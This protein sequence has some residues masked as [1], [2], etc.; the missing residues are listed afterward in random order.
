MRNH[1]SPVDDSR[2]SPG[3]TLWRRVGLV[4]GPLLAALV[5]A[6]P[7]GLHELPGLAS[8]PAAAAAV[9]LWMA[10]WW[11]SEAVPI[12]LTACL[13]LA[14]YP[15]L[16]VA[17][18]GRA[19]SLTLAA[20]GFTDAYIFLFFGG[21]TI[22][23]AMEQWRLHRRIAL[24]IMRLVGTE[25][26]R[27]L[28]GVLIAAE[29]VSLWISNTAT[30]VMMVPIGVALVTELEAREGKRLA[31]YGAALMLAVAYGANV[32]GIG[33]KIGTP[34]NSIFAGFATDRLGVELSFLTFM[35]VGLPFVALFTPVIWWLLWR[36]A[37]RDALGRG[38]AGEV[39]DR[40]LAALG[41][42]S[43]Q[44][45]AVT[46][47]FTAAALLWIFTDVVRPLLAPLVP[48]GF[49]FAG[50][51]YEASV[52]LLAALT[53]AL[54]GKVSLAQLRRVRWDALLLLG[55]S[56]ALASGLEASGLSTWVGGKIQGLSELP[57]L[58]QYAL[59]AGAT[60]ILSAIASNT[61]T[62][63]VMLN[64]LPR[65]LPLLATS[66]MAASCDFALPAGTPP[67]AIVFGSGRVR[68]PVMMKTGVVLDALAVLLLSVWGVLG[69]RLILG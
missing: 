21:M 33:T 41:P 5:Y 43:K 59:T 42:M 55:G 20:A 39:I 14:L 30:A 68:L 61:A 19:E 2:A 6:L 7:S 23:A 69:V 1:P 45:K 60:V 51:H 36:L 67:N 13:P 57:L 18:G 35:A 46:L 58:G 26:R 48:E 17:P 15:A 31:G 66:A 25:P 56:F 52:A 9:A 47:V 8:R 22:G 32:G 24:N 53:L 11:F 28:L 37:R 10:V 16:V 63:N 3:Y 64:L 65:S 50:K 40:E 29:A 49:R 34:T 38:Q 54:W 4:A 12:G 62:L 27:L 44:E